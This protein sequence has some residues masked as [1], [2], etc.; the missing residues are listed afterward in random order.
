MRDLMAELR[1]HRRGDS[2]L[3]VTE[4]DLEE[5]WERARELDGGVDF[6]VTTHGSPATCVRNIGKRIREYR[7][8]IEYLKTKAEVIRTVHRLPREAE[9]S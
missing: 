9:R 5:Y 4:T 3:R 6:W 2:P 1:N 8:Q 7:Q